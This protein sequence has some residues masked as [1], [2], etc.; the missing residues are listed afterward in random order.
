MEYPVFVCH[1]YCW[2]VNETSKKGRDRGFRE[3]F[4]KGRD[5]GFREIF[6]RK[7]TQDIGN[8]ALP[9][10][11][12]EFEINIFNR[13]VGHAYCFAHYGNAGKINYSR[14]IFLGI[15]DWTPHYSAPYRA[16]RTKPCRLKVIFQVYS[17]LGYP[18]T[19]PGFCVELLK[20]SRPSAH[21]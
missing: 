6:S 13:K 20:W 16:T 2:V 14:R 15:R 8:R 3:I 1:L 7:N 11:K 17:S 5:R 21:Q 10:S 4:K 18:S 12:W 9:G 19:F